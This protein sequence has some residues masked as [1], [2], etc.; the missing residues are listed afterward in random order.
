MQTLYFKHHFHF[1]S[2]INSLNAKKIFIR[3]FK[4]LII[5]LLYIEMLGESA[6][7]LEE[8]GLKLVACEIHNPYIHGETN[9]SSL[10]INGHFLCLYTLT[11]KEFIESETLKH[12]ENVNY[13]TKCK[14]PLIRNYSSIG[15]RRFEIAQLVTL[16]GDECVCILKTVWIRIFQ[17]HIKKWI[18]NKQYIS[19]LVK[20]PRFFILRECG[21]YVQDTY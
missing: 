8:Y 17:R 13:I 20:T 9:T 2:L 7:N 21:K 11:Y 19:K 3:L 16:P 5:Y 4:Y 12:T 14:H 10:G 15:T 6:E 18:Q 1:H